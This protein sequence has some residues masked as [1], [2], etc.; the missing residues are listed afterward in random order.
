MEIKAATVVTEV[1]TVEARWVAVDTAFRQ[2]AKEATANRMAEVM[3][4]REAAMEARVASVEDTREET[5]MV[6]IRE[7]DMVEV[8]K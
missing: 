8:N 3:E 1:A 7:V 6:K 2:E 4:A 5:H